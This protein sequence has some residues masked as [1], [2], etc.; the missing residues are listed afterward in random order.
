MMY[1]DRTVTVV[2]PY[3]PK[4]TP[5]EML[6]EAKRSVERQAVPTE[7]LV[8]T[9]AEQ[10]GPAA[11]RNIGLDRAETRHVAFLDADDVW[12]RDKLER[13][14]AQMEQTDAGLCIEGQCA[15]RDEFVYELFIGNLNEVMS[16]VIIDTAQVDTR[17]EQ[18]LIR[19]EDHLFVLEASDA[20]ICFCTDTFTVNYHETSM[21]AGDPN[22]ADYRTQA[23]RYGALVADRVPEAR[24]FL[25]IF[26]RHVYCL[27]G[28]YAHEE[29]KYRTA[30]QQFGYSLRIGFSMYALIGL[31]GSIPPSLV[32]GEKGPEI[33]WSKHV[34]K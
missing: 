27:M 2:I 33:R 15:T 30:A 25:T 34:R 8:V 18:D 21:T 29:G 12:A 6:A 26:Y 28:I 5:T 19:W 13:Q 16:S 24:P 32:F 17:F 3:S 20:G 11:T 23:M 4:H 14:L 22:I 9:D 31:L 1:S 7:L 10:R